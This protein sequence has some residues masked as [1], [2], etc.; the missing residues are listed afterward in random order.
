MAQTTM[1]QLRQ[2]L[3][4]IGGFFMYEGTVIILNGA[5]CSG[6]S[7]TTFQ[8]QKIM[9]EPFLHISADRN[10]STFPNHCWDF[11]SLS[12]GEVDKFLSAHN[13]Y[14]AVLAEY[15]NRV[16]YDTVITEEFDLNECVSFLSPFKVYYVHLSCSNAVLN[17]RE[18]L[19]GDRIIGHAESQVENV[20]SCGPF[21]I[22]VDTTDHAPEQCAVEIKEF[23]ICNPEPSAF[24]T[25]YAH[26]NQ[27]QR[28]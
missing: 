13:R 4:E 24:K 2:A 9:K 18:R 21:D 26:N 3:Y 10:A 22:E 15:G 25:R 1:P 5:S 11:H 8:L 17:K 12:N 16:I 7:A 23:I 28:L 20:L 19:R 6:K 14:I 27:Q